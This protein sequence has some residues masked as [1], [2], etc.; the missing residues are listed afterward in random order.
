MSARDK[1]PVR[2]PSIADVRDYWD[3]RVHDTKLSEDPPGSRGYF[4]AMAGYRY[5]KLAYLADLIDFERWRDR[6]VLDIGCGA[7]L[8]LVRLGRAGARGAGVELSL[9]SLALARQYLDVEG[10]AAVLV[11]ADAAVLP[12]PDDFFDLVLCHGVL[13][14]AVD[15]AGIVR[16]TRRVLRPGGLAMFVAYNRRSW[17]SAL[18]AVSAVA[19]GHGDAPVFRMHTRAELG[20][21][22]APFPQRTIGTAR[23]GWHLV[24]R[25]RKDRDPARNGT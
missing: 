13:P 24:A 19:P 10:V 22:L 12:F 20:A 14:F 25:C 21:L 18:R 7:G 11:Q 9:V 15:P 3:A 6:D 23:G 1:S 4:A 5:S 16:E 2:R 17:M 8:D